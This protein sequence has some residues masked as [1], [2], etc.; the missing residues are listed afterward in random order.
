M[1]KPKASSLTLFFRQFS[2]RRPKR[3]LA[4][5]SKNCK[6]QFRG[7]SL[8][9][10]APLALLALPLLGL[11]IALYLL[12][13][14]RPSAPVASLH[15]WGSIT[16]DRE[17]NSLW[18]RLRVSILLLLQ[19]V[20]LLA[21]IL[22]LARPWVPSRE[23]I[24]QN[25]VIVMDVSASMASRDDPGGPTRLQNAQAKAKQIIDNMP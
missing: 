14:R 25:V 8:G 17:A 2:K 22:A 1:Q 4:R 18:Q 5:R 13:L 3:T 15:L 24:G 11:V 7:K 6:L 20:I 9:L 16:R 23:P 19:V 12:K 21:L 10:F